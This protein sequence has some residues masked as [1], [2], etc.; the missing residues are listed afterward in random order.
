[1]N[2]PSLSGM[3][4]WIAGG[5]PGE[6]SAS[7]LAALSWSIPTQVISIPL[8][9]KRIMQP[10]HGALGFLDPPTLTQADYGRDRSRWASP[11]SLRVTS[12]LLTV[13]RHDRY[14]F[15]SGRESIQIN[16][17]SSTPGLVGTSGQSRGE[18]QTQSAVLRFDAHITGLR[19]V[20]WSCLL[21][22][23]RRWN[24]NKFVVLYQ[25]DAVLS[26]DSVVPDIH[27]ALHG[28]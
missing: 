22:N 4:S 28:V 9:R 21:F 24:T 20:S 2:E 13:G 8:L 16:L 18:L 26:S 27:N 14:K 17:Q 19:Y 7:P 1:M 5:P 11:T 12:G 6:A 10:S 3:V 23:S 15:E 25:L